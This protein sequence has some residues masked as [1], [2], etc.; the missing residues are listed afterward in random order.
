MNTSGLTSKIKTQLEELRQ[1][2]AARDGVSGPAIINS[3]N[4]K[5][6]T[7]INYSEMTMADVE[8]KILSIIGK[9]LF[10]KYGKEILS[11]YFPPL[12]S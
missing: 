3:T 10:Q 11:I 5:L 2:L 6:L 7:E 4:F 12:S 9:T 8:K 1:H